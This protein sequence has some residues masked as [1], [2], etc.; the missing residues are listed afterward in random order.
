MKRFNKQGL[1]LLF[2]VSIFSLIFA[3]IVGRFMYIHVT[4]EVQS[5]D[6][7]S[8]A[9]TYR[10][11]NGTL[12]AE[13]GKIFD[14]S[15]MVLAD[16]RPVYTMYAILDEEYS[17]NSPR[18][19]HVEDPSEVA[20]AIAPI[21]DMEVSEIE[22]TIRSG[23]DND[24]FQV[25]FGNSGSELNEETVGE[26]QDLELS[27]INFEESTQ[28]Y[29][30]NGMYAS[31]VIG[32][33]EDGED[34]PQ[35][36]FGVELEFDEALTGIPGHISYQRDKYGYKLLNAE[37]V[38]QP[39]SDGDN[40][41]LTIDQK[42]QTF[43]EDALTSVDEM[44]EPERIMAAVMDPKTGEIL[45][46]SNRPN[47]NPNTR[48]NIENWYNDVISYPFEP[49]STM[50]I[51]TLAAA[52]EEGVYNGQDTFTSGRFR[53]NENYRYIHDYETSGWGEITYDEGVQR[54][55]NVGFA[56]ILW[57]QLGPERFHDYLED[58]HF[59]RRTGIDLSGERRGSIQYQYAMEQITT[60]FGQGTTVSPIQLMKAATSIANDGEMVKPYVISSVVDSESGN[61]LENNQPESVGE[62]ISP[63]TAEEVKR[64][65]ASSVT[66]DEGTANRFE[67][68]NFSTFGKTGT[69]QI[70]DPESG[71]YMTGSENY[72]F[73][74]LGMA[75][76]DDPELML[77]VAVKQPDID[78][79]SEGSISTSY[80]Y[81]T[82]MENSLHYLDVNPDQEGER[83]VNQAEIPDLIGASTEQAEQ[84]L[85]ELG[86]DVE[87]LGN[88]D[89]VKATNPPS[90]SGVLTNQRILLLT[91]GE[92]SMPDV[93][94]WTLREV[95]ALGQL[96]NLSID[97]VGSGFVTEQSIQPGVTINDDQVLVVE[98]KTKE[99]IRDAKESED[100]ESDEGQDVEEEEENI[101]NEM[102]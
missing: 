82:V 38:V 28:R 22:E 30:P 84:Q 87:V 61:V 56:K 42:I 47:F 72:V 11:A 10:E 66:E 50:K 32:F 96:T 59:D 17:E 51:F 70:P 31:Q 85:Q 102:N 45:A 2:V 52:I 36:S 48:E 8:Y 73:S 81:R 92:T 91:D 27:G 44:Y 80:I 40:V 67:L 62:P 20:S 69:A 76:E 37:E 41:Y 95:L 5:V 79:Y 64:L 24:R 18:A 97:Y 39:P 100:E 13:R 23:I 58:F 14:R 94:D 77:Y 55:S 25:E 98:L 12:E 15:G 26:I 9:E 54:S 60:S 46:M 1:M 65:L 90:G 93:S 29:Y 33:T 7:V 101:D 43:L 86:F 83:H 49:G 6:L 78:H 88:G 68:E 21:L 35:G 89:E 74:F 4:G 75:P 34:Q 57:E 16:N 3:I 99:E 53:I 71:G 63:E 19:L